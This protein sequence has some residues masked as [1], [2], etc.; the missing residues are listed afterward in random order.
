MEPLQRPLTAQTSQQSESRRRGGAVRRGCGGWD[1]QVLSR[2]FKAEAAATPTRCRQ[3]WVVPPSWENAW[4]PLAI[5][6]T[7]IR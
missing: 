4:H 5:P 2:L 1:S 6:M 3:R 7:D